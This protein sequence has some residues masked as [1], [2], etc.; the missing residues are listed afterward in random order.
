MKRLLKND[1]SDDD[2]K[3]KMKKSFTYDDEQEDKDEN[4]I[5]DKY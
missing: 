1:D 2:I 3:P 4:F 5:F